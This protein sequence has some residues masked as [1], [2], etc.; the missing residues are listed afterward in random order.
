MKT[1]SAKSSPV[2]P[3]TRKNT[4]PISAS[5]SFFGEEGY[6][7]LERVWARPTCDVNGIFGGY[8]GEGAKTVLPAWAGAKVSMR[9]VPDQDPDDIAKKFTEYVQSLAPKGVKV[10]VVAH[11]GGAP[12]LVSTDGPVI[13]RGA[14]CVG[15]CLAA[16]R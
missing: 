1:G 9:L 15:R 11:H 10:E 14:R 6:T 7:T 2:Y 12:V 13:E 4:L 5:R 3:S 16:P 8:A